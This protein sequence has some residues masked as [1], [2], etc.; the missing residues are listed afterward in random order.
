MFHFVYV[1]RSLKDNKRYIG[2]T[3]NLNRR[4][5]QHN[6]GKVSS[7][8]GRLPLELIYS[9]KYS[10]RSVAASREKYLKSGTGRKFLEQMNL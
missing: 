5:F 10:D 3:N 6:S 8:R 9:E 4:I 7:T 1:L 2:L